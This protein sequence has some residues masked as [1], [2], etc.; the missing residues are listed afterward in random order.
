MNRRS[1]RSKALRACGSGA[2]RTR[3]GDRTHSNFAIE[4]YRLVVDA[5][6]KVNKVAGAINTARS[7]GLWIA[8]REIALQHRLVL[9][10]VCGRTLKEESASTL[11]QELAP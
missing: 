10:V 6:E 8:D 4:R 3:R 7:R 5:G 2:C 9:Q 11:L 1:C